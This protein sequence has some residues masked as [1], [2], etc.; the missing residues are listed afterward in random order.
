MTLSTRAIDAPHGYSSR[1]PLPEEQQQ[2][3]ARAQ[4]IRR[5]LYGSNIFDKLGVRSRAEAIVFAREH[6]FRS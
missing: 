5:L 6:G 4:H 3:Q 2:R 1:S